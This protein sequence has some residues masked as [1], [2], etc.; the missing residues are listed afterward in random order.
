MIGAF[1]AQGL[2]LADSLRC[3]VCIHGESADLA[4]AAEGERGMLATDLLQH[5]RQLVNNSQ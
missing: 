5:I 3:A 1:I 4:A 2:S